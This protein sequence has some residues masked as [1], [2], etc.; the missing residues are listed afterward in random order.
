MPLFY[1]PV[2]AKSKVSI[3]YYSHNLFYC[4][5]LYL[6][7]IEIFFLQP[8]GFWQCCIEQIFQRHF[9]TVFT[10]FMPLCHIL[11]IL[12]I[13]PIFFHYYYTYDDLGSVIFDVTT[14]S[15]KLTEGS[16]DDQNFLAIKYLLIKV[17][18]LFF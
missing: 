16:E 10:Y 15:L 2:S 1:D 4:T 6:S 9:P 11:V 18:T 7:D 17:C 12:I 3:M 14:T 8:K 13:F 5:L